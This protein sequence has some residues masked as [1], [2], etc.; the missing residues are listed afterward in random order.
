MSEENPS[1][2]SHLSIGSNHFEKALSFYDSVMPTLGARQVMKFEGAVAYGRAY[3]EFWVQSPIDGNPAAP[4][5][6]THISFIAASQEQVRAFWDA[7]LAAGATPDGAPGL[8]AEYGESYYACF[9]RDL[10][11]HKI[12]AAH[13]PITTEVG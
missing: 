9:V 11:G 2:V 3:P 1:I 6:G 5:N 7:A 12:E 8:R 10:D 4:G 13:I